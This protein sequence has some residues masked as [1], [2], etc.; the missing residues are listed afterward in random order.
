MSDACPA[1]APPAADGDAVFLRGLFI[2]RDLFFKMCV[3]W[4]GG[5]RQD[6]EDA[7]SRGTL[8]ALDYHRRHPGKIESFRPWMLRLLQNLCADIREAQDRLTGLPAGDE[9]DEPALASPATGPDRAVYSHELRGALDDAVASLPAWLHAVFCMR[10]V[11][12]VPYP[13]ICRRF[14]ISPVNA[15]QRIQQARRHLRS[16]LGRFT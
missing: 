13:D 4:L 11:D 3:R 15:R 7:L 12:E 2:D 8:R 16:R 9:E 5:N 1:L 10:I 14:Q 6:A